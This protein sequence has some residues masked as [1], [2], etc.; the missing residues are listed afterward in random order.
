[1]N[2]LI[3][4]KRRSRR[5]SG[6]KV[7]K[8]R[9]KVSKRRAS[10]RRSK[11]N[12]RSG[13]KSCKRKSKGKKRCSWVKRKSSGRR[14]HKGYCKRGGSQETPPEPV[15]QDTAKAATQSE[16]GSEETPPEPVA[17]DPALP[18]AIQS[19]QTIILQNQPGSNTQA[20]KGY[21]ENPYYFKGVQHRLIDL[22]ENVTDLGSTDL[23]LYSLRKARAVMLGYD[24]QGLELCH[25][26]AATNPN[27]WHRT[28]K[29]NNLVNYCCRVVSGTGRL[30]SRWTNIEDWTVIEIQDD[31]EQR[32]RTQFKFE[33]K[34]EA[35]K[36]WSVLNDLEW[37]TPPPPRRRPAKKKSSW[38]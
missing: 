20:K 29:P 23:V 5:K 34:E 31:D 33:T 6:R 32:R 18:P 16:K 13:R 19:V 28:G 24:L 10:R 12:R 7:S 3:G 1:M 25:K 11:C 37:N 15:A 22:D 2:S 17:Q 4:G 8:R 35:G 9:S 38:W 26:E 14:K 27:P 21:N 30:S 36:F